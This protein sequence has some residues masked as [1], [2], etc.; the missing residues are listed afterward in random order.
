MLN[1]QRRSEISV[2]VPPEL[3]KLLHRFVRD[4]GALVRT[5][6]LHDYRAESVVAGTDRHAFLRD[7]I[8]EIELSGAVRQGEYIL[9][10]RLPR[11][12]AKTFGFGIVR[13]K[14]LSLPHHRALRKAGSGILPCQFLVQSPLQDRNFTALH[15]LVFRSEPVLRADRLASRR[16]AFQKSSPHLRTRLAFELSCQV[17]HRLLDHLVGQRLGLVLQYE[18]QGIRFFTFGQLSVAGS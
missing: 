6:D 7:P 3:R 17:G 15:N 14:D 4:R 5:L 12:V 2:P 8:A 1:P 16:Q 10:D 9:I 18:T 11:F 13:I